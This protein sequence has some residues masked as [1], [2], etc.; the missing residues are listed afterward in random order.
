MIK[1]NKLRLRKLDTRTNVQILVKPATVH[2]VLIAS[3]K[4]MNPT[5]L[6]SAKVRLLSRCDNWSPFS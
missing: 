1:I 3:G 2:K 4:Y 5:T 6:P